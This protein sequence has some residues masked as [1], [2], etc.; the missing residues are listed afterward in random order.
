MDLSGL[1]IETREPHHAKLL[2]AA[3]DYAWAHSEDTSTKTGAIIYD[4]ELRKIVALGANHYPEGLNPTPE[5]LADRNFKLKK[6]IHAEPS[7]VHYA[8]KYGQQTLDNT[9][10]MPWIPCEPCAAVM[11]DSGIGMFVGHKAM[12]DKTP[13]DWGDSTYDGLVLLKKRGIPAYM[14]VGEIG[15]VDALFRGEK[16]RP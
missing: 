5:E 4:P 7:C 12:I 16:W 6:I 13:N 2:R 11:V 14:Y 3:Y 1:L 15:G 10:Y 9:M 8:A